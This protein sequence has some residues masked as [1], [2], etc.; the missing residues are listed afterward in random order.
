MFIPISNNNHPPFYCRLPSG[1]HPWSWKIKH[2]QT[3]FPF[4]SPFIFP[5]IYIIYIYIC[6]VEFNQT[7]AWPQREAAVGRCQTK[8]C[9]NIFIYIYI[10]SSHPIHIQNISIGIFDCHAWSRVKSPRLRRERMASKWGLAVSSSLRC[11]TSGMAS[12]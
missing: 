3:I 1:N 4:K 12:D 9:S 11:W 6:S 5:F 8:K 2:L 10:Q 7:N